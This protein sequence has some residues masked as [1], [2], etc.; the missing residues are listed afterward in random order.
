VNDQRL[1]PGLAVASLVLGI[2]SIAF[3]LVVIG[4]LF[5]LIGLA[6]GVVYLRRYRAE[7]RGIAMSGVIL[8]VVGMLASAGLGAAYY[9][10]I[11][12]AIGGGT[13]GNF[14]ALAAWEGAAAPDFTVTTLDGEVMSLS[15]LRG[16]RVVVDFWATWCGPCIA[17]VPHYNRLVDE[18]PADELTLIGI[19]KEAPA[20]IEPFVEQHGVTFPIASARDLPEPYS[21]VSGIPTTF[22]IDRNGVIQTVKLGSRGY[23]VLTELALA[24]DFAG[25]VRTGPAQQAVR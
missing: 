1:H 19:S 13:R 22:F 11:Q 14:A 18:T 4:L 10:L 6:L 21:L 3:S 20:V 16:Q 24:D 25:E 2:V 8:S 9:W 23:E 12:Q 7:P 5:G 15:A 17:E